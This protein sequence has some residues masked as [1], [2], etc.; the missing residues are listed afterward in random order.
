[1]E[2]IKQSTSKKFFKW[3]FSFLFLVSFSQ[4]QKGHEM[5]WKQGLFQ[6]ETNWKRGYLGMS[7]PPSLTY[8]N[9]GT[10]LDIYFR[11]GVGGEETKTALVSENFSPSYWQEV[12]QHISTLKIHNKYS[13][14]PKSGH[15]RFSN[16]RR[17]KAVFDIMMLWRIV[18]IW[19]PT[20]WIRKHMKSGLLEGGI[21]NGL[22]FKLLGFSNSYS[23]NHLKTVPF[24]IWMI[25]SGFQM[26]F[27]KMD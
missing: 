22:V 3:L 2:V 20:I 15:V 19:N 9:H 16:G 5:M 13:R 8:S 6:Q 11:D 18:G 25:L 12:T 4:Y 21:S 1:M 14:D 17:F 27:D 26:V 23:P 24:K 10:G 7:F